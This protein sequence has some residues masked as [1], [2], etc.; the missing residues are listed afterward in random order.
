M[1]SRSFSVSPLFSVNGPT[2]PNLSRRT[3]FAGV[4]VAPAGG[5]AMSKLPELKTLA[6]PDGQVGGVIE[7]S[8]PASTSRCVSNVASVGLSDPNSADAG[9]VKKATAAAAVKMT[10]SLRIS[11]LPEARGCTPFAGIRSIA[12]D[13]ESPLTKLKDN[14]L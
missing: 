14:L 9:S 3:R 5:E 13:Y 10:G 7:A 4:N 8:H 12:R 6:V 1:A 11:F 2:T